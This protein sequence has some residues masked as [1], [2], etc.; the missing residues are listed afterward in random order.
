MLVY[1]VGLHDGRSIGTVEAVRA[2][3]NPLIL[4]GA[5]DIPLAP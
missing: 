2:S 1:R 5:V 3:I 4:L